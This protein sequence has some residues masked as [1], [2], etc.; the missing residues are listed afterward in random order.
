MKTYIGID[1]GTSGAIAALGPDDRFITLQPVKT[2]PLG[3][4]LLLDIEGNLDILK[5]IALLAGGLENVV[6]T[7]EK[8]QMNRYFGIKGNFA[9]GQNGEFWRVLLTLS[10]F[11]F[12]LTHARTW[13]TG[14]LKAFRMSL[15]E[16]ADTKGAAKLFLAQRYPDIRLE[17]AFNTQQC[18]GIRDAMCLALWARSNNV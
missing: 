15:P 11:S 4:R 12:A 1:N 9:N 10:G 18:E 7:Y 14:L 5:N 3:R 2:V 8:Q 6:V 17:E 16:K 13:Q